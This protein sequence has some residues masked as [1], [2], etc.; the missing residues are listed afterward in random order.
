M[1]RCIILVL[2]LSCSAY[3][4]RPRDDADPDLFQGDMRLTF[5]QRLLAMT[6]GDVSLAGNSNNVFGSAKD[7][8]MLWLPS[9][10]VPYEI[11]PDLASNPAAMFAIFQGFREWESYACLKFVE[12]TNEQDYIY[13]FNNCSGCWSYV[14]RQG[15]KQE[16][17]LDNGCHSRATVAHELAHAMGFWHEQSRP[18]R[19]NY[20]KIFWENIEK[21]NAYNFNKHDNS[22]VDSLGT[23]YDHYSMMQYDETSFSMNGNL[24]MKAKQRHIVQLGNEVGFTNID[25]AQAMKLYKCNGKTTKQPFKEAQVVL[26]GAN[27]CT[28]DDDW[29]YFTQATDDDF[30]WTLRKGA[31][32]SGGTGPSVDHT[33]GRMGAF[34]YIEASYPRM[35]DD[36]ARL[37]S[38]TFDKSTCMTFHY[39]MYSADPGNMGTLN[40]FVTNLRTNVQRKLWSRT[41]SQGNE[42]KGQSLR[43]DMKEKFQV[44]F[45]GIRGKSY[46]GDIAIDDISFQ[47]GNCNRITKTPSSG[48]CKDTN[49]REG[50][51]CG[52]WKAAG[53][54]DQHKIDM[55]HI[56]RKTCSLCE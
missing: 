37:I 12:R 32:L 55:K 28:F 35:K 50:P 38:K 26:N 46:Q 13:I 52:I 53:L 10:Q 9:K 34:A 16:L 8:S 56:C 6:G 47:D 18:D 39:H 31:T 11:S 43:I 4:F 2:F 44:I 41:G 1:E 45:E 29:C 36:T 17:C 14:G 15:G 24:T 25:S 54:C 19:D 21:D 49:D 33:T 7:Q 30:D 20:I 42:W 22:E 27:D 51:Y 3:A 5:M 40:V 48:R 23:P